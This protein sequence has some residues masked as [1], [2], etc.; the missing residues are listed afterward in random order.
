MWPKPY[1]AWQQKLTFTKALILQCLQH[2]YKLTSYRLL[3]R[4][5]IFLHAS[6]HSAIVAPG[7]L[8]RSAGSGRNK[9]STLESSWH[10]DTC[11]IFFLKFIS[12]NKHRPEGYGWKWILDVRLEWRNTN[13]VLAEFIKIVALIHGCGYNLLALATERRFYCLFI[14]LPE[15]W[16]LCCFRG[17]WQ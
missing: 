5:V 12:K 4:D 17:M 15:T 14:L 16:I 13:F 7:S 11:R 10:Q 6:F 2:S 3:Q 1:Q 9:N 8:P